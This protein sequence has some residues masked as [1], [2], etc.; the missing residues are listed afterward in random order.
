MR[1]IL[2]YYLS[3]PLSDKETHRRKDPANPATP[4]RLP[5]RAT[6]LGI[7]E[8]VMREALPSV[9]FFPLSLTGFVTRSVMSRN[10]R[11]LTSC[12]SAGTLSR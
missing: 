9:C 4:T 7:G 12:V 2:K 6:A 11:I 1:E 3:A 5:F 8:P 10:P